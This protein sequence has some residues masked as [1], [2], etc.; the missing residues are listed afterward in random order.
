[1]YIVGGIVDRNRHKRLTLDKAEVEGIRHA[2][3]PIGAHLKM[4][5]SVVLTV[6]QVLDILLAWLELRD[7][8]LAC[9][10]A[11]PMRKRGLQGNAPGQRLRREGGDEGEE[12]GEDEAE[13]EGPGDQGDAKLLAS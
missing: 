3:L 7:W 10:R 4:S 6:N 2:R 9:E 11:V 8:K 1:M 12:E 13:G 5:G